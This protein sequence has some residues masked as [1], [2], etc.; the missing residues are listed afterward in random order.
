[1]APT[2]D[3][4]ALI[5]QTCECYQLHSRRDFTDMIEGTVCEIGRSAWLTEM[6]LRQSYKPLKTETFLWLLSEMQQKR[7][8]ADIFQQ[9]GS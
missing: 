2:Q 7:S 6:C 8:A 4:Q 5:P 1:M 3:A 9:A